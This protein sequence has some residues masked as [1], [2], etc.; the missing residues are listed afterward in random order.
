MNITV[1]I[2]PNCMCY[3]DEHMMTVIIYHQ[4]RHKPSTDDGQ[5]AGLKALRPD[6]KLSSL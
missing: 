1:I 6:L 5:A 4:L 2:E 3:Y